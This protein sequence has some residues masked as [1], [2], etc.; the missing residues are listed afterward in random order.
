MIKSVVF[1]IG[2]VLKGWHP[3]L[4][5][6]FDAETARAVENA[7]WGSGYWDEMDHG[8]IDEDVLLDMMIAYAPNCEK[9]IRYIYNHLELISERYDYAIPW[10]KELKAAGYQVYF[11]SNYSRH[12]RKTVPETIDFIPYMDGGVFSSDVKL[13]KP[14]PAIY[15]LLCK[16]YSLDPSECLFIDDRQENV[17]GAIACGMHSIRFESYAE[18][19]P[20]IMKYLEDN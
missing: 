15:Q 17:D 8:V 9:Q 3:Q 7:I 20:I 4:D 19:Y 10:V 11:L 13:M 18:S 5:A 16:N 2:K 1:D 12:L 6:Y 14:D